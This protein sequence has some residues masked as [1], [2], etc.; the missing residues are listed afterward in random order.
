MKTTILTAIS[1]AVLATSV[2][3][4]AENYVRPHFTKIVQCIEPSQGYTV[5]PQPQAYA[6]TLETIG[7]QLVEYKIDNQFAIGTGVRNF[8]RFYGT[9]FDAFV[10]QRLREACDDNCTILNVE[11]IDPGPRVDGVNSRPAGLK[12]D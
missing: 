1:A 6:I 5:D 2:S 10:M 4:Q 3:A 11:E 9:P 12:Y 7:G 8:P